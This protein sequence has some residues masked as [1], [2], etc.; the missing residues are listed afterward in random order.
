M[1]TRG[2]LHECRAQ[3][4]ATIMDEFDGDSAAHFESLGIHYAEARAFARETLAANF[5]GFMG[6]EMSSASAL[7]IGLQIGLVLA[8]DGPPADRRPQRMT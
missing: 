2:D 5:A 6:R 8:V 7:V 1:L 4:H 3:I